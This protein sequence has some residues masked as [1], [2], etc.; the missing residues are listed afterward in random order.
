M[1]QLRDHELNPICSVH[2]GLRH[3]PRVHVNQG[4]WDCAEELIAAEKRRKRRSAGDSDRQTNL[5]VAMHEAYQPIID[6]GR[7]RFP[8]D[9]R[10]KARAELEQRLQPRLGSRIPLS[11]STCA[12]HC[13]AGVERPVRGTFLPRSV[14]ASTQSSAIERERAWRQQTQQRLIA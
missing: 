1:A 5:E 3:F 13:K 10:V 6:D 12:R 11:L 4:S 8:E 2:F 14:P 9:L 7:G